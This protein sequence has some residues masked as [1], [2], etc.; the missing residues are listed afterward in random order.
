MISNEQLET[1]RHY[2]VRLPIYTLVDRMPEI[3]EWRSEMVVSSQTMT[4]DYVL[5][6]FEHEHDAVAFSVMFGA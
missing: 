6:A 4:W 1:K 5:F 3:N 2:E